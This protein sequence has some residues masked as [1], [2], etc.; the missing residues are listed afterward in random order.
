MAFVDVNAPYRKIHP[1]MS[2]FIER[3]QLEGLD[4][5]IVCAIHLHHGHPKHHRLRH[6]RLLHLR[7]HMHRRNLLLR[8]V[9]KQPIWVILESIS[10]HLLFSRYIVSGTTEITFRVAFSCS[11]Y[12]AISPILSGISKKHF[13]IYSLTN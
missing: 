11:F 8:C 13:D 10:P 9:V 2:H 12:W 1:P 3:I 4:L 7:L 6:H 5:W